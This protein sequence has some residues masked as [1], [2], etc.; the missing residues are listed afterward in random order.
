LF[1]YSTGGEIY[2]S[3][4]YLAADSVVVI[5]SDD[6][7]L[8]AVHAN[9]LAANFGHTAWTMR[10]AGG[11]R[12]SPAPDL[13][14]DLIVGDMGGK[15]WALGPTVTTGAP[16]APRLEAGGVRATPNPTRG[17]VRFEVGPGA[18]QVPIEIFDL[19]G[20]RVALV[21]P[22]PGGYRWSARRDG[23]QRTASGV[24]FFRLEGTPTRGRLVLVE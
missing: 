21:N 11:V 9:P 23:A 1:K 15:V 20:R 7:L 12:C 10:L 3:P 14:G 18:P 6:S 24:Y 13:A 2:S 22:G 8:Y 4:A 19:R 16:D 5:G 17:E